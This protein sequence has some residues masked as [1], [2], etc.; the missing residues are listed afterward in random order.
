MHPYGAIAITDDR[1]A[2]VNP[3][4]C[5]CL[6][7]SAKPCGIQKTRRKAR[8]RTF[9]G[10]TQR[11][12]ERML[13]RVMV[14][15]THVVHIGAPR[16]TLTLQSR[17]RACPTPF[18]TTVADEPA[19]PKSPSGSGRVSDICWVVDLATT[20]REPPTPDVF[21]YQW[22]HRRRYCAKRPARGLRR[23]IQLHRARG[24]EAASRGNI[25]FARLRHV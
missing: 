21:R 13:V 9:A 2:S 12:D 15:R 19:P 24:G 16:E 6:Y 23:P 5:G 1:S 11:D 18:P 25:Q 20:D 22:G 7:V 14:L 10:L 3:W 4:T 17:A 8:K